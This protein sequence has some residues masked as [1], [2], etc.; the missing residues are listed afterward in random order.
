MPNATWSIPA[1]EMKMG[2]SHKI[3]LN[4]YAL[5]ILEAQQKDFGYFGSAFVFPTFSRLG[6]I[7]RDTLSKALRNFNNS[8]Y[9]DKLTTHGFRAT[10]RTICSLHKAELLQKGISDEIIPFPKAA[11]ANSKD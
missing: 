10:F 9:R 8:K 3:A 1:N 7:H 11:R 5:K 6:H 2:K 4:S